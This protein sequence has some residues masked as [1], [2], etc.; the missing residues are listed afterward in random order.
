MI[1]LQNEQTQENKLEQQRTRQKELINKLKEQLEDL[2]HYAY[3]VS[4]VDSIYSHFHGL[5]IS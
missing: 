1:L 5:K 2:E 3:E 4:M